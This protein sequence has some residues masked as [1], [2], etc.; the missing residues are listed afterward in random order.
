MKKPGCLKVD[1]DVEFG[2]QP[3]KKAHSRVWAGMCFWGKWEK[4]HW[5]AS[6]FTDKRPTQVIK[7]RVI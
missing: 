3:E 4:A 7:G 6:V 1:S 5:L 2:L